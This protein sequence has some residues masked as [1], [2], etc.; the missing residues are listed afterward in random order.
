MLCDRLQLTASM[1]VRFE[2]TD[3]CHT[4][5]FSRLYDDVTPGEVRFGKISLFKT[6]DGL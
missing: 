2:N 3:L 4:F 5:P 1:D 6:C